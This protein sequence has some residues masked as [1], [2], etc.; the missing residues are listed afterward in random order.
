MDSTHDGEGEVAAA[1]R[2]IAKGF[3]A[4]H[5]SAGVARLVRQA[6]KFLPAR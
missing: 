1:F 3:P 5:R 4:P 2:R 6:R